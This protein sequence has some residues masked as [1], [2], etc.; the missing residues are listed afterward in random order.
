MLAT[1]ADQIGQAV[2]Q[3]QLRGEATSAEL[4]RRSDAL[5]S[6]LLESVSHDLRTPLASI[7]ATAGS[8]TDPDLDWSQDERRQATRTIDLEAE[9]LDRLVT[10]LLDMSRVDAGGLRADAEPYPLEDLVRTTL[11]RLRPQVDGRSIEVNIAPDLPLVYVD[12]TFMDQILTNVLGNAVKYAPSSAAIQV[13]AGSSDDPGF[14]RLRVEDGGPGVPDEALPH[15]FDKFYRVPR[16]NEGARRGTGLGLA[17][18]RG[19]TETMGGRIHA[20]RSSLGG[21]ALD[22][23]LPEAP[24]HPG[25]TPGADP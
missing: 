22:I 7:R 20:R 13:E 8:L 9:R 11:R 24:P 17:V 21:L 16:R 2:E 4:A 14:V 5:K 15:L 10:N 18:V 25:A 6:A 3:D 12:P 1:A 19:L 23:D